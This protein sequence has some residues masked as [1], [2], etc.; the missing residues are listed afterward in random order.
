[1]IIVES[2]HMERLTKSL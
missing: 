2:E 1:M